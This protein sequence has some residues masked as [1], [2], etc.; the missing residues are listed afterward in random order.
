MKSIRAKR[1]MAFL[2]DYALSF[3]PCILLATIAFLSV[4]GQIAIFI[5][6]AAVIAFLVFMIFRDWLFNGHSIGKRIFKLTVLDAN[7]LSVPSA[8]QLIIKGLL[9][10]FPLDSLFLIFSGKSLGERAS[11]TIVMLRQSPDTHPFHLDAKT[12]AKPV[13]KRFIIAISVVLCIAL[14]MF[15][16]VS[17]ALQAVKKQENYR[18]A[19]AYLINSDAFSE[20][21][22]DESQITLN[23]Y[24]SKTLRTEDGTSTVV[25]FTFHVRSRQYQVICHRDKDVWYVCEECTDFR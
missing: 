24:S 16:I 18:I 2:T 4:G 12:Q 5:T 10:M 11:G 22:A 19:Y 23:G 6:F 15:L 8:K 7:T 14:V 17:A 3:L 13:K 1:I 21:Q 9:L 25:T 20:I